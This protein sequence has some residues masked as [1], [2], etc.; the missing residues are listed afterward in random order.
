M[1]ESHDEPILT[2]V[3]E[4]TEQAFPDKHEHGKSGAHPNDDYLEARTE[5]E[6]AEIAEDQS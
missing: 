3:I 5:H 1:S 6:R 2:D 4:P